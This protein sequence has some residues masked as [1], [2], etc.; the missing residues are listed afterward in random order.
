MARKPREKLIITAAITG[1]DTAFP[2]QT[3][4]IPITPDE[5]AEATYQ[6]YKAGAAI[7]HIHV[8]DPVTGEP[9]GDIEL[10]RETLQKIRAKAPDVVICQTT[11]GALGMSTQDRLAVIKE[12]KPELA[13]FTTESVST[14][15]L[16]MKDQYEWKHEWEKKL[17]DLS[18]KTSFENTFE[19]MELFG[20]TM[21]ENGTKPECE[22]FGSSGLYNARFLVRQGIVEEPIHMQFIL[23]SL[24]GTGGY[25]WEVTN[26]H[27][28]AL[29]LFGTDNFTW[30]VVGVGYPEEFELAA[31]AISMGGHVRVGIEDSIYV[32]SGQLAKSSA[33]LVEQ[34]VKIA[35]IF[36][37]EIAT[38]TDARRIMGLKGVE[39]TKI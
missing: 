20:R 23:G 6:A 11:G 36:G 22:F 13:S 14:N 39:N 9:S 12:F 16:T 21:K 33:E 26:F 38:P 18:Y 5:I 34:I 28:T 30:S 29:R 31:I 35:E 27:T 17:I 24:G 7:V 3:S 8:R 4:A 15:L 19:N 10:W 32:R 25:A 37:R 1:S 2:S